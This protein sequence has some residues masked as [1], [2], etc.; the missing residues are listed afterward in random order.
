MK[1]NPIDLSHLHGDLNMFLD[2][3]DKLP[4]KKIEKT[5]K[6]IRRIKLSGLYEELYNPPIMTI[7]FLSFFYNE[8]RD[9]KV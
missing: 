2:E 5:F 9:N 7:S 6:H 8:K 3:K 4:I 1:K